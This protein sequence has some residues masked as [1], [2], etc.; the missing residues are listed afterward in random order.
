MG[1][2]LGLGLGLRLGIGLGVRSPQPTSKPR[3]WRGSSAF[4]IQLSP[5]AMGGMTTRRRVSSPSRSSLAANMSNS[6]IRLKRSGSPSVTSSGPAAAHAARRAA[7]VAAE[8][9]AAARAETQ[10]SGTTASAE[11]C[12]SP[13]A[14]SRVRRPHCSWRRPAMCIMTQGTLCWGAQSLRSGALMV[15][16][17]QSEEWQRRIAPK[18]SP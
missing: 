17:L 11:G 7:G 4:C 8:A 1:L 5:H 16:Q 10:A 9:A 14:R 15:R 3:R 12:H 2:R 6:P 18:K 13:S